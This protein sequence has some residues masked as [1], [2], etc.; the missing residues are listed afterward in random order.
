MKLSKALAKILHA[1]LENL[2]SCVSADVT[3]VY[4]GARVHSSG[5]AI[6]CWIATSHKDIQRV[7]TLQSALEIIE[8][9]K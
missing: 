4:R 5:H 7:R 9:I 6:D 8:R 1:A 2:C 3:G